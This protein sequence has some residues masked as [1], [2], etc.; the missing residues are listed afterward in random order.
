MDGLEYTIRI[1]KYSK[2]P[3]NGKIY[4]RKTGDSYRFDRLVLWN[5]DIYNDSICKARFTAIWVRK[6]QIGILIKRISK[7]Y[8]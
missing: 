8:F 5:I 3:F 7:E 1:I 6:W 4:G 2:Q